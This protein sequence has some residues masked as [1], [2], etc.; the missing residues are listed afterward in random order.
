VTPLT[1]RDWIPADGDSVQLFLDSAQVALWNDAESG[2][3]GARL[4]LL[5]D[6]ERLQILEAGL[7][8]MT[9]SSIDPDTVLIL[10]ARVRDFTIV[11]DVEPAPP[12]DGMRLGGVPSW[13]TVLDVTVAGTLDGPP[14]LCA[15]VGCPF[16]L[17][18]RHVSYAGL[19]LR[20]RSPADAFQPTDS[21]AL[22]V[23]PVLSRA[24]LP[25]S[26]LGSSLIA[27]QLGQRLAPALFGALEGSSVEVPITD[28]V[29]AFL[30]GLDP[31][32]RPPPG[33]LALLS[34]PEPASFTFAEFFGPGGPNEPVLKLVVTVSPP[35]EL[36]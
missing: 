24:S 10:D 15:A 25:K 18:P 11:Y 27:D 12:A 19:A 7:R 31:S 26:P 8:L 34:A 33:T 23:R 35:M 2:A 32:G 3:S 28:Y 22:D 4:E 1:T 29:K 17:L 5:T 21:V 30:T 14:E 20:S 36:Q 6:G 9:R 16:T 13:R